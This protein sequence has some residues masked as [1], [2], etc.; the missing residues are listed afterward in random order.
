MKKTR[1]KIIIIVCILIAAGIG[2]FF[3]EMHLRFGRQKKIWKKARHVLESA[4][5]TIMKMNII[6][7]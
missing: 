3:L 6:V 2:V 1:S 7:W 5:C 4:I